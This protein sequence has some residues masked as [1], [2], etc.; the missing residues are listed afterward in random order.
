MNTHK[1]PD[2]EVWQ[3]FVAKAQ[4]KKTPL[5]I[6]PELK[7]VWE[8]CRLDQKYDLW[9]PP[10][11]AKG[12]T[13]TSLLRSKK[14]LLNI[15]IPI[16]EDLYE[17]TEQTPCTFLLSDEA[18]CTLYLCH[19][20]DVKA[21]L[22]PLGIEEGAYWHQNRIG[23]NAISNVLRHAQVTTSI[24]YEHFKEALHDFAIFAAPI[25]DERGNL[26]ACL[27]LIFLVNERNLCATALVHSAAHDIA[28]Q[29]QAEQLLD[30]SNQHF[31]EVHTLLDGADEGILSWLPDGTIHYFNHKGS[32]MLGLTEQDLGKN[33]NALFKIPTKLGRAI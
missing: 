12:V 21:K 2:K 3:H 1:K 15:A 27:A 32:R 33:I 10:Y 7:R 19:H 22:D 14:Q 28:T 18:G 20:P 6:D 26:Q 17:H 13:F 24:Q 30:E 31:S 9:T 23:N 16:I 5:D 25:F 11:K 4:T 8:E 29:L